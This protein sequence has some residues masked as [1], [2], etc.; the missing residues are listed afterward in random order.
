MHSLN[1]STFADFPFTNCIQSFEGILDYVFYESDSF[2]LA[3]VIPLPSVEKCKENT[4]LPSQYIPSDHLPIIF[5]LVA[6]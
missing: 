3:K 6:K 2:E 1:L 5:E 4:A